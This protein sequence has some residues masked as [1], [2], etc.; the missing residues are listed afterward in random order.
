MSRWLMPTF[1]DEDAWVENQWR[2]YS[3][4]GEPMLVS[5]ETYRKKRHTTWNQVNDLRKLFR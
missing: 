5:E 1:P 3:T 4:S 2:S